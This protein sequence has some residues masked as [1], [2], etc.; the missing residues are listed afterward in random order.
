MLVIGFS[1]FIISFLLIS[2]LTKALLSSSVEE[3]HISLL[4]SD[5]P[6][7][8][9]LTPYMWLLAGVLVTVLIQSSTIVTSALVPLVS[10]RVITLGE[11]DILKHLLDQFL[12]PIGA[13]GVTMFVRSF[14]SKMSRAV[15]I[16]LS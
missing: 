6:L 11:E 1:M 13:Q 9:W 3:R 8:P 5:L 2:R 4:S 16:H 10:S 15:N 7:L 12:A 14:S